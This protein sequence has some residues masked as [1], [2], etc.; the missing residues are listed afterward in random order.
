[1]SARRDDYESAP[2][3]TGRIAFDEGWYLLRLGPEIFTLLGGALDTLDFPITRT[4]SP[5]VS[6]IK[7]ERPAKKE[8]KFGRAFVNELVT[9]RVHPVLRHHN[10]RHVW[11]DCASDR[12]CELRQ[13]FALPTL[14]HEGR[15]LVSF[16]ITLARID[17]P[18]TPTPR[19]EMR[20]TPSSH[21]DVETGMQ[22]L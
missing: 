18:V 9:V 12:L 4:E 5:H 7:E 2:E 14:V 6:I 22:H 11:V 10:G 16:H 1:M 3:V 15:F 17:T 20:L 8:A 13:Y 19:D 21:I